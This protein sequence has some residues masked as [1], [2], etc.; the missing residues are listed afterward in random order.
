MPAYNGDTL[1][2]NYLNIDNVHFSGTP[3]AVSQGGKTYMGA[4]DTTINSYVYGRVYDTK[5]PDGKFS[6]GVALDNVC[7]FRTANFYWIT[8]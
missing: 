2:S 7:L 6:A 3:S 5:N 1:T 8:C 4:G